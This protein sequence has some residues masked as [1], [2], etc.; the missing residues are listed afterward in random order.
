MGAK[1]SQEMKKA[2]RLVRAG[3][4]AYAAAKAAGVTRGAIS[5]APWYREFIAAQTPKRK[6]RK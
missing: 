6:A 2:E 4:T 5:K 1:Q 3:S